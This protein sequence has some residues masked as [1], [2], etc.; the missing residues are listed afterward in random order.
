MKS[1]AIL[2]L[3][4]LSFCY[5]NAQILFEEVGNAVNFNFTNSIQ[6]GTGVSL[7][8]FD[9][10][11]WDDISCPSNEGE[12]IAFFKNNNG[13]FQQIQL[14]IVDP[15]TATKQVVSVSYTHLTLPT[16]A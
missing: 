15:L 4:L 3:C 5:G 1:I 11:G 13:S 14:D 6:Y 16:K 12:S 9:G 8:D 7:C 2:L 10:D